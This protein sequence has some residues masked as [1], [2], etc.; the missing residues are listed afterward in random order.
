MSGN[1]YEAACPNCDE[2][3]QCY[4]DY[5]PHDYVSGE[6]LS[7]GFDYHTK[8]RQMGLRELNDM[9]S[10][11][12]EDWGLEGEDQLQ[13][14]EKLP[15]MH[16]HIAEWVDPDTVRGYWKDQFVK[17]DHIQSL[18]GKFP[19]GH[20]VSEAAKDLI[21]ALDDCAFDEDEVEYVLQKGS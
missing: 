2:T 19:E 4:S 9:R 10:M 8:S 3:M 7:C 13:P 12:N 14:L 16:P 18:I 5:K 21:S 11:R 1:S 20:P 6:C 15:P 17:Y